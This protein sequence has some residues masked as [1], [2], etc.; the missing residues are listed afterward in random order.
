MWPN[1]ALCN[2]HA[3]EIFE[4]KMNLGKLNPILNSGQMLAT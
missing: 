3:F 1:L 4:W 2:G